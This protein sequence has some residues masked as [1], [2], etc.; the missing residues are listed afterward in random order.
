MDV[1][2]TDNS[3]KFKSA[4]SKAKMAALEAI[5]LQAEG[6]A[7]LEL[8]KKHAVDTG[9][10][11]NSVTYAVSG[12]HA[13]IGSYRANK[14]DKSGSYNGTAPNDAIAGVYIGTNV[15][16]GIYVEMGRSGSKVGPRPF[17]K[18]AATEHTEE[19]KN[20]AKKYLTDA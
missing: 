20:I 12:Q 18:P 16:Y 4:M 10:L 11:R 8:E 2:I 5:G 17:I 3:D 6:Y 13:A 9:L 1:K 7:K 14:G 15:E 19:Y